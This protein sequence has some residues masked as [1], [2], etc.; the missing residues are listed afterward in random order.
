MAYP[1]AEL[2]SGV[3]GSGVQRIHDKGW[4]GRRLA[5]C[6]NWRLGFR[7]TLRPL[8]AS[9]SVC[10]NAERRPINNHVT[11]LC[12]EVHDTAMKVVV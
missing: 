9:P 12:Y 10:G 3:E 6:F 5:V 7:S 8:N 2:K 1:V 11:T 4:D